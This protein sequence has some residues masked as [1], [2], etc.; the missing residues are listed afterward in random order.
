M[1]KIC[2]LALMCFS[3]TQVKAQKGVV[4]KV[5]YLPNHDYKISVNS[6]VKFNVNLT[7][8]QELLDKLNSQGITNPVDAILSVSLNGDTKTGAMS[9]DKTF[10]LN[11]DYK[12]SNISV[13]ANG[14]QM[15]IPPKVT[16]KDLKMVGHISEDWKLKI[17]SA[18]GKVVVDSTEK[19]MQQMM[20]LFQ[21]QIQFP[22]KALKPGDTFTQGSPMDIPM[23]QG[24]PIHIDAG[25]TYKLVSISGGKAYFDMIPNFG[26]NFQ[27]KAVSINVSGTGTGKMVY[28][29][30][31]NFPISKEGTINMKIKVT[32]DK[33]NVDGT[34]VINT[35]YSCTIN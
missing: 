30:K 17:D 6:D 23:T 26:M 28:D 5:K 1:K 16:E 32:S 35:K 22:D 12:I 4:L 10:P 19:K 33:L 20:D 31:N 9:A 18:D 21:K 27:I 29:I 25:I 34:A 8:D 7:G 14:K 15:P 13:T 24:Q 3:L 2:F 11:M